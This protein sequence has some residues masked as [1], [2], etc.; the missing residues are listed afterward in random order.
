M[1]FLQTLAK[2]KKEKAQIKNN[3]Q[4]IK[5]AQILTCVA[6]GKLLKFMRKISE[7]YNTI[8]LN[9]LDLYEKNASSFIIS[10]LLDFRYSF[11]SF[12][13]HLENLKQINLTKNSKKLTNKIK[14]YTEAINEINES[15]IEIY[16]KFLVLIQFNQKSKQNLRNSFIEVIKDTEIPLHTSEKDIK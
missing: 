3:L 5:T 10:N 13:E 8:D 12:K 9:T 15:F 4:E 2:N 16:S 7:E 6:M 14:H 11:N 1:N